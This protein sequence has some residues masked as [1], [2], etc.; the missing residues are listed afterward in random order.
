MRVRIA[1]TGSYA[2]K[3]VVTNA[4]LEKLVETNDAWIVERTGIRER[5]RADADEATSDMA[6]GRRAGARGPAGARMSST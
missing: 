6:P 5:R 1:G 4:D 2:P 3:T